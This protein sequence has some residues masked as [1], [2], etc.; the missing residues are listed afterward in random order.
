MIASPMYLVSVLVPVYKVEKYIERC[1]RSLFGQ[2]YPYLEFVFVDDCSPDNSIDL[3]E[4][5]SDEYP[6]LKPRIKIL[7]HESNKGLASTRNTL[8][9][10][11]E[12]LFVCHVDS[13]DW[14]EPHAIE[15]MVRQQV[16][17]GADI[18]SGT[19]YMHTVDGIVELVEPNY[20]DKKEMILQ[21]FE[22]SLDHV[23]WRRLIR[24]SLYTENHLKCLD[25]CDMAEDR[26]QMA[27]LSFF[28]S[29]FAKVDDVVYNYERRNENSIMYQYVKKD[30]ILRKQK[31]YLGNWMGLYHFFYDKEGD[32]RNESAQQALLYANTYLKKSI[33]LGS[34]QDFLH[35]IDCID[36]IDDCFWPIIGW[37][38]GGLQGLVL[39]NY[40]YRKAV[41]TKE[42]I[43]RYIER[44]VI[45]YSKINNV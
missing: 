38:R 29:S 16:K 4:S 1:A 15:L 28:A 39:H 45:K 6:S 19:A 44:K 41:D 23:I 35:A 36:S 30:T 20:H 31:E 32:F 18:V 42:R 10:N 2:S 9:N 43:C 8:L 11:A 7:H 21:Q 40:L 26:Y 14:L 33:R 24:R 12:G 13:D 34:K 25:G 37:Q 5:I 3:L 17:T 22:Y 27:I